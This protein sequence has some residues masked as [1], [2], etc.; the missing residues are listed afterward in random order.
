MDKIEDIKKLKALLDQGAISKEEFDSLKSKLM[1]DAGSNHP[2]EN[3]KEPVLKHSD[4]S[5]IEQPNLNPAG[6]ET[7]VKF[8]K[9]VSL[10]SIFAVLTVLIIISLIVL[11][12]I[13]NP[14][15]AVKEKNDWS[16]QK[17]RG[18]VKTIET[19]NLSTN[20]SMLDFTVFKFDNKGNCIE[21]SLNNVPT[22]HSY[23]KSG[24]R[25]ESKT[26]MQGIIKYLYDDKRNLIS[27]NYYNSDVLSAKYEYKYDDMGKIIWSNNNGLEV[28]YKY[29][30]K[31]DQ[32]ELIA[33]K[34]D[35]YKQENTWDSKN[36]EK[37]EYKYDKSGNA[38][39]RIYSNPDNGKVMLRTTCK[40]DKW[41]N[42]IEE[43][44]KSEKGSGLNQSYKYN[45]DN[46]GNWIKK[47]GYSNGKMEQVYERTIEY[48]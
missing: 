39:E 35:K 4:K 28:S 42:V 7:A 15:S 36:D 10:K 23:D 30:K 38:I 41:G 22:T 6:K 13:F 31:G 45:Y 18:K 1:I 25:I 21:E 20:G 37:H 5:P 11:I 12:R 17:L 2:D 43:I 8:K 40:F 33:R 14:T 46:A 16:A 47:S 34:S 3:K 19:K 44:S 48:F 9:K 29:D 27:V 24:L 32:I 26:G